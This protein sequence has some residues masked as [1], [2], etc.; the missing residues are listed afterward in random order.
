MPRS[1]LSTRLKQLRSV[2]AE[3]RAEPVQPA[4]AGAIPNN[5]LQ[6]MGFEACGEF[7]YRRTEYLP[8]ERAGLS[9]PARS[10]FFLAPD[11]DPSRLVFFDVESTGLSGG[12]G[13]L[14]FL[15]GFG[16]FTD[17]GFLLEQFFLADYPGE[18]E[19]LEALQ[20]YL[21]PK[22][23]LVSY[24]GRSFDAHLLI[25]RGL[26]N[27]IRYRYGAH[28]D[29][30]YL[31]RRLWRSRIGSCNLGRIEEEILNI[32]REED[33]PSAEVP[34]RWFRFLKEG[35]ARGLKQVFSHHRQDVLSLAQLLTRIESILSHPGD[36]EGIDKRALG[37]YLLSRDA[38]TGEL[39]LR[40]AFEEGDAQAGALLAI[41]LKRRER[42]AEALE[43]WLQTDL[44]QPRSSV[45]E[46]L[47]KYYEHR[48]PDLTVA[49]LWA[50]KGFSLLD[51][52]QASEARRKAFDHRISRLR[53]KI[54]D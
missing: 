28:Y 31:S 35:D 24:N 41:A 9:P 16:S 25:S 54:G 30:L 4:S 33:L 36:V 48:E 17:A 34:E 22:T 8:P 6:E 3:G 5:Q 19:F 11:T 13:T 7:I 12:A 40:E 14:A 43:C 18:G 23:P 29:L 51:A 37:I 21:N 15:A 20:K 26:M 39:L 47:A 38:E 1:G 52:E 44:M 50:E 10:G 42:W 53:R 49:L 32:R 27:G 45:C 2:K 46:E